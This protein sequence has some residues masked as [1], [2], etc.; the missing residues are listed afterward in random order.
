MPGQV[1]MVPTFMVFNALQLTNSYIPLWMMAAAN[2]FNVFLFKN[3]FDSISISL[4]EAAQ[5]DGCTDIGIFA[6][7]IIPLATPIIMYITITAVNASWSDFL[8]P[9][10]LM[11]DDRLMPT[12]VKLYRM[13]SSTRLDYY[14]LAIIFGMIPPT[15]MYAIFQR[16]ILGGVNVGGVKG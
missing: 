7:I 3:Y 2:I 1:R 12:A 10:I 16:K 11:T 15:V 4:I 13:K 14:M 5:I 8:W 9:Y 6:K